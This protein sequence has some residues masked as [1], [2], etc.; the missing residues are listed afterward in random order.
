MGV[1]WE[2][3]EEAKALF[4][5]LIPCGNRARPTVE[6]VLNSRRLPPFPTFPFFLSFL[7]IFL[8][9]FLLEI[10][11]RDGTERLDEYFRVPRSFRS[12]GSGRREKRA[13]EGECPEVSS[14]FP[15][16]SRETRSSSL[17]LYKRK[18]TDQF[19]IQKSTPRALYYLDVRKG[20]ER[21]NRASLSLL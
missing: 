6:N 10:A 8:R 21:L 18:R 16:A 15:S 7:L 19:Q 4:E 17:S 14:T 20:Q 9:I 1:C 5:G 11:S 2:E 3:E 13:W 12:L